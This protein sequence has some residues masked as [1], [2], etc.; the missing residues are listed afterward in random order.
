MTAD[1]AVGW[2]RAAG[3]P[4]TAVVVP[5][6]VV[7]LVVAAANRLIPVLRGGG[8]AGVL[9][10]DDAV[11]YAGSVGLVHGRLP[12][13]D[14]LFLHPPGVLLALA[15]VAGLG[16]WVG[17]VTGWEASRLVWMAMGCLTSLIVALILLPLGRIA[18]LVGGCLYAV[19]PGAVLVERTTLP[20]GL[21]NLCLAAALAL[22][23]R[24]LGSARLVGDATR[25]RPWLTLAVAGALLGFSTTVKVWGVVPLAVICVFVAVVLGARRGLVVALGAATVIIAVCLPFFLA[26]PS[27]MWRM[28]VLDQL[29]RDQNTALLERAAEIAT[30]GRVTSGGFGLVAVL[31]GLVGLVACSLLAWRCRPYRVLVPVLASLVALLLSAPIFYPHYLGV[32]AVPGALLVGVATGVLTDLPRRRGWRLAVAMVG[33]LALALDVLALSRIRSGDSIP[34]ELAGPV[35]SETGCL[36]SDDPNNLLALGVVG[37]N[38]DRGCELVVDLGG[39]SHDLSRGQRIPRSRNPAWQQLVVDYLGSGEY[40]LATRFA[41]GRGLSTATATEIDSWPVRLHVEEYELR[42]PPR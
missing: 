6:F 3:P 2:R 23:I 19:F 32:L 11:Y 14:F 40:A 1:A 33:C 35:Q 36:T 5:V 21:T 20:E 8:L 38:V 42:E 17:E 39:H 25:G 12:Y 29:G 27:A 9:G 41:E 7:V 37:R 13:Q 18:A 15:P 28:V 22:V 16:R 26:A 30:M 10:Y 34:P 31:L 4:E 24:E